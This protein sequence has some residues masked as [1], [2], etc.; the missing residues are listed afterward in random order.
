V[1]TAAGR[2]QISNYLKLVVQFCKQ[3]ASSD[4]GKLDL[5]PLQKMH[6]PN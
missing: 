1:N 3:Y 4:A 6:Q 2:V 5:S